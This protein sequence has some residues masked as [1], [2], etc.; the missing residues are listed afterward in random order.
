LVGIL[1]IVGT[2]AGR[3]ALTGGLL[4]ATRSGQADAEVRSKLRY[5]GYPVRGL[6]A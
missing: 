6:I 4:I 5:S 3:L 2:A 1:T